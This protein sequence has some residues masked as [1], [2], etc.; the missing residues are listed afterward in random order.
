MS[1]LT[2]KVHESKQSLEP[3]TYRIESMYY[4]GYR[5]FPA[6]NKNGIYHE[7]VGSN[8]TNTDALLG[9]MTT[10]TGYDEGFR[11]ILIDSSNKGLPC[12][13]LEGPKDREWVVNF[14]LTTGTVQDAI[15]EL[16][17]RGVTID[18]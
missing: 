7:Y 15:A 10:V 17:Q 2:I 8:I 13:T 6:Y 16:A 3:V 11:V 12:F 18:V 5:K 1:K 4:D 14:E 9:V